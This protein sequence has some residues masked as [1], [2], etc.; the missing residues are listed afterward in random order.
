[1]NIS[2]FE[3]RKPKETL[4]QINLLI[5]MQKCTDKKIGGGPAGAEI[6]RHFLDPNTDDDGWDW[7][8]F[9][10]ELEKLKKLFKEGK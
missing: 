5:E 3:R 6:K 2:E 9:R 10:D 7:Y 8:I 1:M 4:A